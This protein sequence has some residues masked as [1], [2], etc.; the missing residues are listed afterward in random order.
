MLLPRVAHQGEAPRRPSGPASARCRAGGTAGAWSAGGAAA[1][2]AGAVGRDGAAVGGRGGGGRWPG[3][4]QGWSAGGVAGGGR[5]RPGRGRVGLVGGGAG[6][7]GAVGART[8]QEDGGT[9]TAATVPPPAASRRSSERRCEKVARRRRAQQPAGAPVGS[10]V[11][12]R[13]DEDGVVEVGQGSSEGERSR[14]ARWHRRAAP[15]RSWGGVARTADAP[16]P[17]LL[18]GATVVRQRVLTPCQLIG[19][20]ARRPEAGTAVEAPAQGSARSAEPVATPAPSRPAVPGERRALSGCRTGRC[21]GAAGPTATGGRLGGRRRTAVA[22]ADRA[23]RMWRAG[24]RGTRGPPARARGHAGCAS[25]P[26]GHAAAGPQRRATA[27]RARAARRRAGR[28]A[29]RPAPVGPSARNGVGGR[30]DRRPHVSQP[31]MIGGEPWRAS[32]SASRGPAGE[33]GTS[34][35][36]TGSRIGPGRRQAEQAGGGPT[37]A[38]DRGR[39]RLA[40]RDA[41]RTHPPD[42]E[43]TP[44]Y[45]HAGTGAGLDRPACRRR[46][47]GVAWLRQSGRG[48]GRRRPSPRPSASQV[49]RATRCR[50]RARPGRPASPRHRAGRTGSRSGPRRRP[51]RNVAAPSP[52]TSTTAGTGVETTGAPQAMASTG[53]SPKPS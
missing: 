45:R 31:V 15:A 30:R 6:P 46:A 9:T 47:D 50:H 48:T 21:S 10:D 38:T 3:W 44:V 35:A 51:G 11:A 22:A 8:D 39:P 7:V 37:G 43:P 29:G 24:G 18:P 13:E 32:R 14:G 16:G 5:R 26:R 17:R 12:V 41:P 27:A 53:G 33:P 42:G 40:P 23:V 2:G 1:G 52:T 49:R 34:P 28:H 4:W 36:A 25:V 19:R 20:F